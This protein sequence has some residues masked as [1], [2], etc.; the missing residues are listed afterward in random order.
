MR[1]KFV[2]L[3]DEQRKDII[4]GTFMHIYYYLYNNNR[5]MKPDEKSFKHA[6]R[7]I[8]KDLLK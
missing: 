7:A 4:H 2:Q 6:L 1:N 8:S 5:P 3:N